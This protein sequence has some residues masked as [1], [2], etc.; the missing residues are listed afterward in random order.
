MDQ[1]RIE[2]QAVAED[3]TA[4]FIPKSLPRWGFNDKWIKLFV[5]FREVSAL[6]L[7]H[8]ALELGIMYLNLGSPWLSS[9]SLFVMPRWLDA[10]TG[11]HGCLDCFRFLACLNGA[12]EMWSRSG[13]YRANHCGRWSDSPAWRSCRACPLDLPPLC[14]WLHLLTRTSWITEQFIRCL[15]QCLLPVYSVINLSSKVDVTRA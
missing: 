12:S 1:I 4:A 2:S 5:F 7:K 14:T 13:A 6:L 8:Y 15:E 9:S 10:L 3:W 11:A